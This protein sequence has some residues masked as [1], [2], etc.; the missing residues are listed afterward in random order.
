LGERPP[1]RGSSQLPVSLRSWL[2]V[3]SCLNMERVC[4]KLTGHA[5]DCQQ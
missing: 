5:A 1:A 4:H 3:A 2:W